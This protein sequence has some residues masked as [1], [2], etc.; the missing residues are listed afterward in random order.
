[1]LFRIYKKPGGHLHNWMDANEVWE[2]ATGNKVGGLPERR[3]KCR[4]DTWELWLLIP[5]QKHVVVISISSE[6]Q[7]NDQKERI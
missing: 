2:Y 5:A 7:Q 3:Q 1:M 4:G 6:Q